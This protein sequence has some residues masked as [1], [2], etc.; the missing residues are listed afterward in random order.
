M[1]FTTCANFLNLGKFG[2]GPNG[3]INYEGSFE[4]AAL[5]T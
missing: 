2:F 1:A 3:K 4:N 5:F